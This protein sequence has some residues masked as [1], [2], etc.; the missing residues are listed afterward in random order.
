[1][2]SCWITSHLLP[3][4]RAAQS[5]FSELRQSDKQRCSYPLRTCGNIYNKEIF[6]MEEVITYRIATADDAPVMSELGQLLNSVHHAA[7]PD[8]YAAATEDFARD[9]PHWTGVFEKPGQI[10]FI[11]SAGE[12]P[13]AFITA[14]LSASSGPLMQ[15]QNVVRIGSVCVAQP[16]WGK[17]IGRALIQR[18]KDWAIE[19]NAQDL[20]LTVW[21]F[22]ERA[23]RMYAE[24]GFETR[25]LEMGVRL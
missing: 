22:N 10:V 23:V 18:V 8:I 25:A 17:G 15:P 12:R 16:F 13:V 20:R 5:V 19:Q 11:A 7:R 14:I 24:F 1:V 6:I 21:P 2:K 9:L 3:L 4:H